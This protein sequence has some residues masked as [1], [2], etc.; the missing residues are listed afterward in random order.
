M[1]QHR[2]IFC[3]ERHRAVRDERIRSEGVAG[4]AKERRGAGI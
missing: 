4:L 3:D 1:Q 2:A